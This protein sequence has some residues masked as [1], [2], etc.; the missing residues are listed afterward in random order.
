MDESERKRLGPLLWI[1]RCSRRFRVMVAVLVAVPMLYVLSF[2]PA[3][4]LEDRTGW[5]SQHALTTVYSP[6]V[7]A[8]LNQIPPIPLI[9][10]LDW[11]ASAGA[12]RGDRLTALLKT[13]ITEDINRE[14]ER[15]GL[16]L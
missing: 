11:Y 13:S 16:K 8:L 12:V 3:C 14:A 7:S 6:I 15:R 4:W 1:G 2:G 9:R 5:P 10:A